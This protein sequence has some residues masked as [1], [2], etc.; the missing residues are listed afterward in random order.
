MANVSP[1]A[2]ARTQVAGGGGRLGSIRPER[3]LLFAVAALVFFGLVMVYSTSSATALLTEGNPLDMVTRQAL[4][5]IAGV[6]AY[7]VFVRMSPAGLRR[8]APV[9]MLG[10]GALLLLV[11]IP[12][13]GTSVNGSRRWISLGMFNIQPSELA[14]LA[15]VLW[16]AQMAATYPARLRE[17]RGLVP[18]FGL[19]GLFCLLIVVE[20]DMDT[21]LVIGATVMAMLAVAGAQLRHLALV[22]AGAG[23]AGA[24]GIL[25][26]PY[27]LQRLMAF[28][29]PNSAADA[30]AYQGLQ[31]Q[32]AIGVG[33]VTGV[34][35]GDGVQ[36][37]SYLPEAHTDMILAT[38]GE[39]LGLIGVCGVLIGFGI[40]AWAGFRIA[41][42]AR[43][44]HQQLMAAGITTMVVVQAVINMGAVLGVLP[45]AGLTLPFVSFGGSSLII[46]LAG[47]G[48]LVSIGHRT[49]STAIS[50][51]RRRATEGGDR[52]QRDGGAR[53]ART[54][55]GRRTAGA[56]R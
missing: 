33:G 11:L 18:Y 53:D 40:F 29:D 13:I 35:L 46:L 28:M 49:Q 7:M 3:A 56:R 43:D 15:L 31:A 50:L 4:Y 14:K 5:A 30:A 1:V 32:I 21:T 36:K 51:D 34:G 19:T 26:E 42:G 47:T 55:G 10:T 54:G 16:V 48:I 39:E 27:R 17:G 22:V 52:R 20:P 12:G 45:M 8:L 38:V 2:G 25:M 6:A 24:I 44:L 41:V 9:A 37:A 23:V